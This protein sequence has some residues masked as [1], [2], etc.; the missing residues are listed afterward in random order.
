ML[1][2]CL[3]LRDEYSIAAV[4]NDIFTRE[5]AEF[6]TKHHALPPERIQYVKPPTPQFPIICP[7]FFHIAPTISH[8]ISSTNSPPPFPPEQ[9]KQAA[10]PTPQSAK[11]YP[12]TSTPSHIS[13]RSSQP[14]SSSSNPAGT[15]SPQTTVA[16]S[17]IS[18]STSSMSLAV[19]KSLERV[20]PASRA[21][22]CWW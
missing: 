13:T 1:A 8:H 14:T 18:S 21:V 11:T 3:A 12:P 17:P 22:I 16:N 10:V 4:T 15:I 7:P 20:A 19:I 5:D 9:S 6:L 2:L